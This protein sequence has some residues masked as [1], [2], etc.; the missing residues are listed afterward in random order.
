MP[1]DFWLALQQDW[2]L[3]QAM[4]SPA[5]KRIEKTRADFRLSG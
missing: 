3:W 2:D 1:A 4:R 5:A